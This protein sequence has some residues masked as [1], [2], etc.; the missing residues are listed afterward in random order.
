MSDILN[1]DW[2]AMCDGQ[3]LK[4]VGIFVKYHRLEQNKTQ[5]MLAKEAGI[6]RSTLSLL[7]RGEIVTV[8]TLIR[9][10]RVLRKLFVIDGFIVSPQISPILI[11]KAQKI[12]KL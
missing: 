8:D 2:Y 7:E 5:S 3:I 10:L 1:N 9:V 12:K 6:S 4:Q 11:A